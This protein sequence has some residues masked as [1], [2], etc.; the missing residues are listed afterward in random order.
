MQTQTNTPECAAAHVPV[1]GGLPALL[2]GAGGRTQHGL[3]VYV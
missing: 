3:C 2:L 1:P